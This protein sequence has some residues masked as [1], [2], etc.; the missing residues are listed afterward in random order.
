V[1]G[2]GEWAPG[3]LLNLVELLGVRVG[4]WN[5]FAYP[6]NMPAPG[7]HSAEAITAGHGAV[8]V[9]DQIIRDLHALRGQLADELRA[10]DDAHMART[11][12]LLAEARDRREAGGSR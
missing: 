11:D 9:I 6:G 5:H 12:E 8:Q 7:E 2:T 1:S 3:P 4:A 10:D